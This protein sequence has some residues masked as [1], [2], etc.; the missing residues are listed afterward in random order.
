MDSVKKNYERRSPFLNAVNHNIMTSGPKVAY[1]CMKN[2]GDYMSSW[3][4]PGIETRPRL[5]LLVRA[6]DQIRHNRK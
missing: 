3:P 5:T 1:K 6:S 2:F 4:N